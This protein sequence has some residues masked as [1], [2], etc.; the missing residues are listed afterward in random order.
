MKTSITTLGIAI[1]LALSAGAA[2]AAETAGFASY[3]DVIHM[4]DTNSD[5]M[6][7]HDEVMGFSSPD[8]V[9]FQ[10]F[11]VDHWAAFDTDGD[12]MVSM[13]EIDAGM[14]AQNMTD[15]DMLRM[16]FENTGFQ[17]PK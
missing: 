4:A 9:G 12:G 15:K 10:P 8:A 5:G 11:M 6:L 17:P 14:K 2:P 1:A 16:F 7:T 3:L 13:D